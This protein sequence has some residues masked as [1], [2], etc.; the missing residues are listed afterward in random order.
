MMTFADPR[1]VEEVFDE[2]ARKAF[3]DAY[4]E[5]SLHFQHQLHEHPLLSLEALAAM[6]GEMKE[7]D[8]EYNR[9]DLPIGIAPEDVPSNGLAIAETIRTI[10]DNGSWMVLKNIEQLPAYRDLLTDLLKQLEPVVKAT[11]GEMLTP[12]GYIFIS[13][14]GSVTPF[15]FDPEHNVLLH[16]RGTKVMTVFPA[17]DTCFASDQAHETY[18]AGGHRNLEWNDSLADGGK[19]VAL[20]PGDAVYVPVMAP[21]WVKVDDQS[22]ISLSIT[23]RSDWSYH[24]SEARRTNALLRRLGIDPKA[25]PRWPGNPFWKS[26]IWRGARRLGLVR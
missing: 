12:Q 16:L 1:P 6:S 19:K 24:E 2:S 4:P 15:H 7:S 8:I 22:A 13:S 17:G 23:W 5:Q 10:D 25:P 3:A 9:A 18:H 14:P 26:F 21:H 20:A 11:T